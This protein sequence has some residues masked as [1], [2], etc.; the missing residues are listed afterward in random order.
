MDRYEHA[1]NVF[2]KHKDQKPPKL[3]ALE[4]PKDI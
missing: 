4:N 3:S 1:D 2:E